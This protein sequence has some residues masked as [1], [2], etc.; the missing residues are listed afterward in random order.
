MLSRI[1]LCVLQCS[2]ESKY[3]HETDS[4]KLLLAVASRVN[5]FLLVDLYHLQKENS[6][7]F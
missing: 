2:F 3:L 4:I 1:T 6:F 5:Q 7:T